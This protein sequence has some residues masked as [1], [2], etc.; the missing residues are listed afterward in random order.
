[1]PASWPHA[2]AAVG[3]ASTPPCVWTSVASGTPPS[4][5]LAAFAQF[6]Q[7]L[8]PGARVAIQGVDHRLVGEDAG[9]LHDQVELLAAERG[10]SGVNSAVLDEES[11]DGLVS[12][13]DGNGQWGRN[14]IVVQF[15]DV[16][17][18]LTHQRF[19]NVCVAFLRRNMHWSGLP[20]SISMLTMSVKPFSA[21]MN[22]RVAPVSVLA[23]FTLAL[24]R[25]VGML[26]ISVWR[27]TRW[28]VHG[29][30]G[31]P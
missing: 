4:H 12:L 22:S 2:A 21:A 9:S 16:S 15:V 31:M 18:T 29:C 6:A 17:M 27:A 13:E 28:A 23:W 14:V 11:R 19:D 30:H 1:M 20:R 8:T 10:D 7:L 25:S 26:I 5:A 24:T 3:S